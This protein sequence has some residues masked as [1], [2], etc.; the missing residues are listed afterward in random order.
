LEEQA[1]L[2][3]R[4]MLVQMDDRDGGTRPMADSPYRFSQA[5]SGV[6]GPAP[7]RGEH[8]REVLKDWLGMGDA[9]IEAW[10]QSAAV[11]A[12]PDATGN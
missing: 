6:R 4:G 1:T 5:R 8:N 10:L 11:V 3:H 12:A 9:D 7:H 2:K